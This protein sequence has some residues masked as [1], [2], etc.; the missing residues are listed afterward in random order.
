MRLI[1]QILTA[2]VIFGHVSSFLLPLNQRARQ[3][4]TH[5]LQMAQISEQLAKKNIDKVVAQLRRDKSALSELGKLDKVTTIL[6]YG[7]PSA[8][9]IAVRFNASFRKGGFG[10]SAV[11]LP[12]GLGQT[13]ESEGRGTMVGQVKATVSEST[14]KV[15]SCSVFRD[16]GYGR[17][18]NLKV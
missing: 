8:D 1:V 5:S 2:I 15:T 12:F 14:G 4:A 16:L 18:F 7:S 11:P 17:A 10:L 6:G 3:P 13:N 9:N